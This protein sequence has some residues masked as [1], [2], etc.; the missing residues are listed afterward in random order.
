MLLIEMHMLNLERQTKILELIDERGKVEVGELARRFHI[1]EVT[2]RNDLKDLHRRGLIRR[3]HGG[4]IRIE[5]VK[6]DPSLQVKAA[7]HADEK[8]RI[9]VAAA[10]LI[11]DGD[12][13]ILDSG[14]TTQYIA[15]QIKDRKE[16]TVITNGINI[17]MELLGARDVRL[18]LI[19]GMVRQ[20]SYSAVGHF[21]E[22]MLRQLSADK[23][24][25]AVD[26]FDLDFGLST[27][28]PEESKVNQAMVQIANEK[29]LVA[30]SSK[31]GKRSLSRI[32]PLSAIDKVI[33][34]DALTAETQA[35]LRARGVD[36][37]LV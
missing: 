30:D 16:L 34:D 12:S 10:A 6:V 4:A 9:G 18:V 2:I 19:G 28:N 14:T 1:S 24:F 25:L 7:L 8:Q 35:E 27:P 15:K 36:L 20:N 33:T 13:V 23:L 32:V 3:A 21:A 26:A 29:I 17:A 22:D 31:F 37:V 11:K 5:T